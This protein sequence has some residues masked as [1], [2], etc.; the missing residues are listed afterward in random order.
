MPMVRRADDHCIHV[1]EFEEFPIIDE[2]ARLRAEF[3]PGFLPTRC[4]NVANRNEFGRPDLVDRDIEQVPATA[5][6][7]QSAEADAV[8]CTEDAAV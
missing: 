2:L 4:I 1:L 8:I 5:S 3:C 7:A 6:G